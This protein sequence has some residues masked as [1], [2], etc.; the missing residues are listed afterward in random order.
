MNPP[1]FS[2]VTVG[3][4]LGVGVIALFGAYVH[5]R[6]TTRM[7]QTRLAV[8]LLEADDSAIVKELESLVDKGEIEPLQGAYI[9]DPVA[10]P[11]PKPT[12]KSTGAARPASRKKTASAKKSAPTLKTRLRRKKS[13]LE[14]EVEEAAVRLVGASENPFPM[15]PQGI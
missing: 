6:V 13:E 3:D 15:E 10:E 14:H 11:T 4:I 7:R 1:M 2:N 9:V 8:G 5:Y 12:P